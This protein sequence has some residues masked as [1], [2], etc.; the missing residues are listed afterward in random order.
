[1]EYNTLA[2][3]EALNRASEALAQNNFHVVVVGTKEEALAKIKEMIPEGASVMNGTSTT[4]EQI[5]YVEYLKSGEHK[6]VNLHEAILAEKDP[7]KQAALRKQ[8]V[9]SD[10]YLGSAHAV[11]ET[12][13]LVFGSNTGSQ[14]PHL[15]FTSSNIILVVSTKK[16]MPSLSDALDRLLQHV[17]PLEDERL[18]KV[19]GAHTTYAKTLILHKENPMMKRNVTVLFV[20]EDLGF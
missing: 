5:G 11:S 1:M 12:G 17:V 16:I 6:W 14:M 9:I 7:A 3:K 13:E 18:M 8:S 19:Y 20:E 15:V 2:S 10:Y 4:L